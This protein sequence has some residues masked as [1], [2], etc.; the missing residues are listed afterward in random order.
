[1]K[2]TNYISANILSLLGNIT[3]LV[4]VCFFILKTCSEIT[5][6]QLIIFVNYYFY[7]LIIV[8]LL[9]LIFII[10]KFLTNKFNKT[11]INI[12]IKNKT[13]KYIHRIIF[14]TGFIFSALNFILLLSYLILCLIIGLSNHTN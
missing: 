2:I 12:E 9:M 4:T 10:E 1:M 8:I 14:F 11:V 3:I 5:Y 13:I 7:Y 6:N